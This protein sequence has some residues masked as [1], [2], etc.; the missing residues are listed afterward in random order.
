MFGSLSFGNVRVYNL[1]LDGSGTNWPDSKNSA[2]F[3]DAAAGD[4]K[5]VCNETIYFDEPV[6]LARS[7]Y[8]YLGS[9]WLSAPEGCEVFDVE[10]AKAGGPLRFGFRRVSP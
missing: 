3:R 1:Y 5:F 9:C 4:F 10:T 2:W 6:E 8:V 7:R